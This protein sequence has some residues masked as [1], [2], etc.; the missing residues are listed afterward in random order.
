MTLL[1]RPRLTAP[2]ALLAAGLSAS[3]TA[4]P[5]GAVDLQFF[6]PLAVG[7]AAAGVV[8]QMVQTYMAENPG[9][10]ITAIHAGGYS[11]TFTRT[12]TAVRGGTPPNLAILL[13]T[14]MFTL[15]D[16]DIIL[17]WD[18]LVSAEEGQAWFGSFFP[19]FMNNSQTGGQTWGIPFKRSTPVMFYNRDAFRAA[20]L[21]PDSPPATWDEMVAAGRA[22]TL[23]DASGA[24]TQWGVRIPSSGFPSWLM[25]GLVASAGQDGL[26]NRDGT[27][28]MFNTPETIAAL[29]YL[30]SLSTEHGIMEPGILDWGAT[31]RAFLDGNA[32][33]AWT[34][35][36]NL[37][38]ILREATFDV[39]VAMLPAKVRRGTPT[40]GGN[41]YIF[42]GQS[43]EQMQAAV[44]F[45]RWATAPEQSAFWSINT[46]FVATSPAAWETEAMVAHVARVP[47]AAVARDQLAFAVPELSTF[48]GPRV[49][50]IINDHIA[51]AIVGQM[52]PAEAMAAAQSAADAVLRPFR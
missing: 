10:N 19:A 27:E 17:P 16:E 9:V 43:P 21:D 5:A 46:G 24:V 49:T 51:A 38:M 6:F 13:S 36:G 39:G 29:S 37:S 41:F 22:L 45:V 32:A 11:D 3:V 48:E 23:R 47:A 33:M 30:V 28:V 2:A 15:I 25:T 14:D 35:T 8:E 31:P 52:T 40:G 50:Q 34:T 20:G 26:A 44:D 1:A 42:Q 4:A 7:A 12:L 18:D